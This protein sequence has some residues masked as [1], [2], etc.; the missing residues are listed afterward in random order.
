M[1]HTLYV[2]LTALSAALVLAACGGGPKKCT[3]NADCTTAGEICNLSTG[4]CQAGGGAGGGGGSGGGVGGGAGGGGGSGG[5]VGG[6]GGAGGGGGGGGGGQMVQDAGPGG[7]TCEMAA[8]LGNGAWAGTNVGAMN[9]YDPTDSSCT[10]GENPGPDVVYQVH[11][12]N[13]QRLTASATP[14]LNP[15]PTGEQFDLSL[16]LIQAPAANCNAVNPADGGSGI[17]CLGGSDSTSS[18]EATESATWFNDGGTDVDVFVVVDSYWA[19][20]EMNPDGGVGATNVGSFV[21]NI[22]VNPPPADEVCAGATPLMPNMTV[23][24]STFGYGPDYANGSGAMGCEVGTNGPDRAYSLTVPP[25]QRAVVT[26]TPAG[27]FTPSLNLIDAATG[28]DAMPRVCVGGSPADNAPRTAV[29]TNQGASPVNLF[30]IVD[31]YVD[32][33]GDYTIGYTVGTPPADDTCTTATTVLATTGATVNG[34]LTGFAPDYSS[35]GNQCYSASGNDRVYKVTIPAGQVFRATVTPADMSL[36]VVLNLVQGPASAC[37]SS[38]RACLAAS[39]SGYGGEPD[40]LTWFNGTSA[41]VDAFFTVADYDGTATVTDFTI[42]ATVMPPPAGDVCGNATAITASGTL[43]MQN[44]T[45]FMQQYDFSDMSC[46]GGYTGPE[47]VY[48]VT[49]N[50]GQTLTVTATPDMNGDPALSLIEG[51]ASNCTDAAMCLDSSDTGYS[52]DPETVTYTNSSGAAKTIF[53]VVGSWDPTMN[54]DL[55]VQLAP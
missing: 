35:G 19:A 20:P 42:T 37:D 1:T 18:L 27:N 9:S 23:P 36:D 38:G 41:A 6:G 10:G 14:A 4:S 5:G 12:P 2:R 48:S 8:L 30:A 26:V 33:F 28:C 21:L 39:D 29:Y 50:N 7:D 54:F 53:I 3:S 34:N 25:G 16:Y 51:P 31:S 32:T 46:A 43:S 47:R 44:L 15:G 11:V 45:G 40:T 13:G 22:G 52:G 24:G 17:V 49:V 55:N